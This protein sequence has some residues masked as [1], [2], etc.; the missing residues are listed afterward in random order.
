M[1]AIRAKRGPRTPARWEASSHSFGL[2]RG[3]FQTSRVGGLRIG[4]DLGF[5][6]F[7]PALV[8]ALR[9]EATDREDFMSSFRYTCRPPSNS[10][11]TDATLT[12]IEAMV[13]LS[14]MT[15]ARAKSIVS[16][17]KE[18]QIRQL[19]PNSAVCSDSGEILAYT[20]GI[21]TNR[22]SRK[23]RLSRPTRS[24]DCQSLA[25][26]ARPRASLK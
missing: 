4:K 11:R 5:P 6:R 17:G 10:A 13:A 23:C 3:F 14:G 15:V 21:E 16:F 7:V 8:A 24:R 2:P 22:L 18:S 12:S 19:T 26:A 9:G 1:G 25:P 20:P